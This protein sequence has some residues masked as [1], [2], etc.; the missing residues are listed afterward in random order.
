VNALAIEMQLPSASDL[1]ALFRR[2][3]GDPLRLGWR[4]VMNHRFGYFPTEAWYQA[5]VERL[6][7][8]G[9][10]WV[11]VGG[12]KSIFSHSGKLARELVGRCA[13]VV[14]VDPNDNLDENDLV[15][16]RVKSM[17]EEF[18]SDE[19]FDLAT[20]RMVAEHIT[21]PKLEVTSFADL[22]RPG[23][24]VVVY[25][26]NRWSPASIAASVIP[27]PWHRFFTRWLWNSNAE[28]VFPTYYRM[29]TRKR[30]RELF[31]EA[32]FHEVAFARLDNCSLFARF[33]ATCFAELCFWKVL[34][35]V[36]VRYP[37]SDLLGVYQRNCPTCVRG[38]GEEAR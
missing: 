35:T 1:D 38:G 13:L 23:G 16:R 7:M 11:D 15:H 31:E 36:G 6:V 27:D 25:T 26:P 5:V 19:R 8:P 37:E 20:L 9:C 34:R 33:R 10:R 32:G 12:G 2:I 22:I 3:R 28:D 18:R 14:G 30:L 4:V 21:K 17:I 24:H 29:N